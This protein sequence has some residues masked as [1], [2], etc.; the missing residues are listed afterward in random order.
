MNLSGTYVLNIASFIFN[1][2]TNED[3]NLYRCSCSC[4]SIQYLIYSM[5]I[6]LLMMHLLPLD[7]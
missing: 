7:H 2:N 1:A 4:S 5:Y 6:C 3:D